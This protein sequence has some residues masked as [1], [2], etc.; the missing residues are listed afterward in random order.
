MLKLRPYCEILE[1]IIEEVLLMV[2]Y[3]ML[4]LMDKLSSLSNHQSYHWGFVLVILI[5]FAIV[6]LYLLIFSAQLAELLADYLSTKG[7]TEK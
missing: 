2:A 7:L 3:L 5:P 4:S 1:I 6:C